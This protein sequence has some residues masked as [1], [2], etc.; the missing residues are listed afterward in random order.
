MM[1]LLQSL[2]GA[3]RSLFRTQRDLAIEKLPCV[4]TSAC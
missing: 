3:V 2:L 1:T 4:T